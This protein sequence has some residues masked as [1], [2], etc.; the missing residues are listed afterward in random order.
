MAKSPSHILGEL[1]G[2]F[3]EDIMKAPISRLCNKYNV[4]FDTI[5]PRPAR[6][7]NKISWTD[8]NG[9]KH[10]L[11]Y[12]IE[13]DGT[14][15]K[16][17]VPIAF[18]ELAWRRYTKH[19]KNKAQEISGAIIPIAEKYKE[20]APFKGVILSGVFTEPSL[21][22]LENQGFNILYIPYEKI[23]NAFKK[24]GVDIYF[25]EKT[26]EQELS[27]IVDRFRNCTVL[28][29]IAEELI[30]ANKEDICAFVDV[31]ELS[32][33]KQIDYIFVLPLHGKE[34]HFNSLNSAI[35]YIQGYSKIPK[36]ATIDRYVVG[37][38]FND[39]S[40]INCVFKDKLM[41][42]DFLKRNSQY[43]AN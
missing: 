34:M 13:R 43:A 37:I 16:I 33:K 1:I 5:G 23:V 32:I 17:G 18:I 4:Y 3:F 14:P 11:D 15:D 7:T 9:S 30:A 41:A 26:S 25:D 22:Q 36:D 35:S 24:Y 6:R 19:S 10:D 40:Q 31:L 21:K 29:K 27:T 8:I 38:F 28:D 39:G 12:V 42:I 2:N 20:Y